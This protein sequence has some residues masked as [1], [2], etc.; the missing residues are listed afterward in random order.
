MRVWADRCAGLDVHKKTVV[1]CCIVPDA[2]GG[3]ELVEKRTF[4]TTT[5][6]L[7]DLSD[8]IAEKGCTHV[9]M[10]STG[11]Y[12]RPVYNILEAREAF[13]IFVVNAAHVKAVPGRKT[14]VRDAHWI[15]DLLRYGL[16]KKSF[17]PAPEQRDIRE[18]TRLRTKFVQERTSM[19]NRVQKT[20]ETA[21]IKLGSVASNVNGVSGRA[22]LAAMIAGETDP[23]ILADLAKGVLRKKRDQ[24]SAALNGHV[25]DH[26]RI[27]L[28]ELLAQIDNLDESIERLSAAIDEAMKAAEAPFVQAVELLITIPGVQRTAAQKILGEI[29]ANMDRFNGPAQLASLCRVAPGSNQSAGKNRSGKICQGSVPPRQALLEIAMAAV[30]TKDT[31]PFAQYQRLSR[32]IGKGRAIVAVAHSLLEAMYWML[33]DQV[34]YKDLGGDYFTAGRE[35][36]IIQNL[37]KR[38]SDFGY[39]VTLDPIPIAA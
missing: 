36:H 6:E 9:A 30:K 3:H 5:N 33:K 17:V 16:L 24:L 39:F 34:P 18:L 21:N 2:D 8:W 25:R 37:T 35:Q 27:I 28:T 20:L 4:G 14:D 15:A 1:A 29:G 10:E 31:Y 13:D 23:A 11:V 12:W 38:L 7:L 22:M 19:V 32:R 26:H